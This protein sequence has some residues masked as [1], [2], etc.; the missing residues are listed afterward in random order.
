MQETLLGGRKDSAWDNLAVTVQESLKKWQQ[1]EGGECKWENSATIHQSMWT[2]SDADV[3]P[4]WQG[5][6]FGGTHLLPTYHLLITYCQLSFLIRRWR[7]TSC[8]E[9]NKNSHLAKKCPLQCSRLYPVKFV[10]LSWTTNLSET[11][12]VGSFKISI[13]VMVDSGQFHLSYLQTHK[14]QWI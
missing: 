9:D 3:G 11:W 2:V 14:S 13:I 10:L 5:Q 1:S 7:S 6:Y 4:R 8:G 12:G